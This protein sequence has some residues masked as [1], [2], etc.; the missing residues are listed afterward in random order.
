[1]PVSLRRIQAR[2]FSLV[3]VLVSLTIVGLAGAALLLASETATQAGNDAVS[4]TIA[5]GIADQIVDEVLGKRYVEPGEAATVL[6]LGVEAGEGNV[7][8]KTNLF[9]DSDDY[10]GIELA[11]PLD[12]VGI[13]L[14]FGDGNGALRAEDFRIGDTFFSNWRVVVAI[15]YVDEANP[16]VDLTSTATSGM[17]A[18]TVTVYRQGN[19]TTDQLAQVRRVFSY[20]ALPGA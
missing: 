1:M 16:S 5:R 15:T 13:P 17:R 12:P 3:E 14:G 18:V 10:H 7:P 6:P 2:A 20:V 8:L 19:G 9:D 11:P 4:A